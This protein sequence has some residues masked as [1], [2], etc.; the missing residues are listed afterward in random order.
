MYRDVITFMGRQR[1]F[2]IE[3]K[4]DNVGTSTSSQFTIPTTGGAYNYSVTTQEHNLSGLTGSTTLTFSTPGTYQIEIRGVFSRIFFN[5]LGDRLK[6]LRVVQWGDISWVSFVNAFNGCSNMDVTASDTPRLSGVVTLQSCF[7]GCSSL[8][9][10]NGSIGSWNT[11]TITNMATVFNNATQF[12]QNLGAW[13]VS[14]VLFFSAMF[15]GATNFNNGGSSDINNW[16]LRTTGTIDMSSIFRSTS[17]NQPIG[18]WTT[19]AVTNMAGM[20]FGCVT[21]NQAIGSWN[22]AAVQ[23]MSQV[24]FNNTSFNQDISGWNTSAVKNMTQMFSSAS[25][26]NQPIGTWNTSAV[27]TMFLMFQSA[28]SFNQDISS[29]DTSS[30]TNMQFMF[31]SAIAFNQNISSWNVSA[32]TTF[33]QIFQGA[34]AFNQNLSAWT[35][36][37]TGITNMD[38]FFRSSGM[39]T[40]NYTDTLVGWANYVFNN[41]SP[42]SLALTVQTS[43]TFQ[44]SRS[45]GAN[46]ANAGA[47][48]TYLT[49]ATPTGAGWTITGDTVIA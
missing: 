26:F 3:V 16:S 42:Y 20:F 39:S 24:F 43:R 25:S 7:V 18:S 4:T 45:G 19:S 13:N 6:L 2:V 29:W 35:L 32:V 33:G 21:F 15:Q 23:N 41:S 12:N 28:T 17:F 14:S 27:T 31:N 46:F 49:T 22:T 40:A 30:V 5:N 38:S 36:K 9:N 11:T 47:A 37:L 10:A 34:T 1:A 48:R 44:N 8:I